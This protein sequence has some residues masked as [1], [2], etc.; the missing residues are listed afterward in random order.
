[1]TGLVAFRP[2]MLAAAGAGLLGGTVLGSLM[3]RKN[4][5]SVAIPLAALLV[6]AVVAHV[7][8]LGAQLL[9]RG[10]WWSNLALGLCLCTLGS[11]SERGAGAMLVVGTGAALLFA[12]RRALAGAGASR[13]AKP[14]RHAGTVQIV[15]I[16]A[17]AD[18]L[19]LL[20]VGTLS[21]DSYSH[22][23]SAYLFFAAALALVV[24][25]VGLY[26]LA[27]WGVLVTMG[28]ALTLAVVLG[29]ELVSTD[30]D[31][32]APLLIV[33]AIQLATP[34]PMLYSLAARRPLPALSPRLRSMLADVVVVAVMATGLVAAAVR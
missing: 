25:F 14:A 3:I 31:F 5:P 24:G 21:A 4:E 19:T 2:R 20:L 11:V 15:M 9:A 22:R 12:E 7:Q 28:T 34:L 13:G 30:S 8:R 17:L 26:R 23:T 32:R 1:M 16:L 6:A 33:S 10:L 27:L 29:A 18:A